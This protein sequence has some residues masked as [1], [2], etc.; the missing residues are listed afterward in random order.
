MA[1]FNHCPPWNSGVDRYSSL[2]SQIATISKGASVERP[3]RQS[4]SPKGID[5]SKN[6]KLNGQSRANT[7]NCKQTAVPKKSF[8]KRQLHQFKRSRVG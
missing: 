2:S 4:R 8:Y 6:L 1:V 7:A 3:G 5:V